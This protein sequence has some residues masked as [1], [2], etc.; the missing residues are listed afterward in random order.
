MRFDLFGDLDRLDAAAWAAH[1]APDAVMR[2]GSADPV[3]SRASC[4]AAVAGVLARFRSI[5]HQIIEIWQHGGATI[6]ETS[7]AVT[8]DDGSEIEVPSVTIYRTDASR[9]I[10]DYR[11]YHDLGAVLA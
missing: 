11:V 7:L 1:L 9:L 2:C 5:H 8:T 6:C 4:Q 10:A 3:H